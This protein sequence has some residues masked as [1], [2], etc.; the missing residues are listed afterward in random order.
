MPPMLNT[1][2]GSRK[3]SFALG[4][5][6]YPS[7][8]YEKLSSARC[9]ILWIFSSSFHGCRH[10]AYPHGLSLGRYF[11]LIALTLFLLKPNLICNISQTWTYSRSLCDFEAH[12]R[13]KYVVNLLFPRP[14]L[15]RPKKL[16]GSA[17]GTGSTGC[18]S[19]KGLFTTYLT[20]EWAVDSHI[21][22]ERVLVW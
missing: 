17:T 10:F 19:I 6:S 13:V 12:S 4:Y 3:E 1:F 11:S 16:A 21:D 2:N 22:L 9:R 20:Q 18:R 5:T 8:L 14:T 7:K 15:T